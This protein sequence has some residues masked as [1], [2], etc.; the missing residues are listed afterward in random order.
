MRD[1]GDSVRIMQRDEAAAR[2]GFAA[3]IASGIVDEARTWA[4]LTPVRRDDLRRA[5][6]LVLA[7]YEIDPATALDEGYKACNKHLALNV[8]YAFVGAVIGYYR[9]WGV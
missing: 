2:T 9:Q 8:S 1:L 4:K 6:E 5:S 7:A 3:Q